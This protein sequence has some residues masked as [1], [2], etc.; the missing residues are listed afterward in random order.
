MENTITQLA[1]RQATPS[2]THCVFN[3]PAPFEGTN[4]FTSDPLLQHMVRKGEAE[5]A[6]DCLVSYG[7]KAGDDLMTDGHLANR[8]LPE[9]EPHDRYGHRINQVNYHEAYHR[10]M[11][12]GVAAN[13]PSL[14]WTQPRSGAH[15]ARAA[16]MYLHGQADSGTCCPLT[17]TFAAVPVLRRNANVARD[18][19]PGILSPTYDPA[20]APIN[21]KKGLTIGM[22][23]TEK[24]GGTDV[25]ANTTGAIP[26]PG[27]RTD[28]Y[29]ITGH[30]WFCSA[31][32]CDGFLI[33]AQTPQGLSCFLMPRWRPDGRL[34]DIYIQRLKNKMGN[35]SNASSEIE[36]RGA[37]ALLMGAPGRGVPVIIEM[38]MLTRYDC[39][40]GSSGL[41]RQALAQALHHCRHR[42]VGGRPLDQ[43]PLMKNVLA[44]LALESAGATALTFRMSMALDRMA[45]HP[46]E[47]LLLRL[48]TAIGKFWICKRATSA[49]AEAQECLGGIGYVEDSILPRLLR[50]APVN[51]IWEGSGNVQCVDVMRAM[52]KSPDSLEAL[53]QWCGRQAP[54]NPLL[55]QAFGQMQHSLGQAGNLEAQAR[56]CIQQAALVMQASALLEL[57]HPLAADFCKAR[58]SANRGYVFGTLPEQVDVDSVI[59]HSLH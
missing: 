22:A 53:L 44:D 6:W 19:L 57:G 1:D 26:L 24:Q 35:R 54:H 4:L 29:E 36:M 50:E 12:S 28:E 5:W 46:V 20:N 37:Y 13:M 30:K 9:F 43:Y 45:Q 58:L 40:L 7:Q 56:H 38:V 39:M 33:L 59:K 8:Y 49:I 21:Q 18:W 34:N 48:A 15:V 47:A 10:L 2:D 42:T 11:A 31:P 52:Q 25:R 51:S 27:G 55:E 23:M 32:M 14:P 41:M 3:Q 17:M 16:L